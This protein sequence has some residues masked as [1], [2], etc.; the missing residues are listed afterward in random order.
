MFGIDFGSIGSSLIGGLAGGL[1]NKIPGFKDLA[2]SALKL[3]DALPIDELRDF[4]KNN[5]GIDPKDILSFVFPPGAM[6]LEVRDQLANMMNGRGAPEKGSKEWS[7]M[8]NSARFSI[9]DIFG[10]M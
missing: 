2:G 6:A 5:L 1:L 7:D 3:F 10:N 8:F 4:A 9:F